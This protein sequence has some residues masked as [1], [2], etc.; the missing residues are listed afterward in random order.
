MSNNYADAVVIGLLCLIFIVA[1]VIYGP[2]LT[3][4]GINMLVLYHIPG[5]SP[6]P[7][8]LFTGYWWASLLGG[9]LIGGIIGGATKKK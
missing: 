4:W 9:G 7:Y 6:L 3:M 5:A 1:A 2:V 8:E